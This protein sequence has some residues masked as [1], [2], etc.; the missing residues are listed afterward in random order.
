[1]LQLPGM[2]QRSSILLDVVHIFHL[3]Y[4]MDLG[5]STLVLLAKLGYFGNHRSLDRRLEEAY[6]AFDLWCKSS[7]RT[8]SIDE[9]STVNFKM[10]QKCLDF[11]MNWVCILNGHV[12]SLR[13]KGFPV[14]LHGKAFDTALILAWL[15]SHMA[16]IQAARSSEA[17]DLVART[18]LVRLAL[19]SLRATV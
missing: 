11:L 7:G 9:F 19:L 5:S 16:N 12:T 17:C 3:G 14:S 1:M 15:E 6:D 10:T 13:S 18:L 2:E 8:S 4:G